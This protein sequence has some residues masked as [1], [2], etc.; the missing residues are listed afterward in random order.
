MIGPITFKPDDE[1]WNEEHTEGYRFTSDFTTGEKLGPDD[2]I[3]LGAAT[4][5]GPHHVPFWF[6]MLLSGHAQADMRN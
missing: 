5:I 1:V 4:N 6:W 2:V 3:P